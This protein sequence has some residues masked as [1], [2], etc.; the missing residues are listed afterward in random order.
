ML[1]QM[2]RRGTL[3]T[4]CFLILSVVGIV[5]ALQ[6]PVQMIPD[7]DVR[8]ISVRTQWPGASPQDVESEVLI[9][10][11]QFLR[12]VPNLSR[13]TAV[14][15]SGEATIEL[16]FPFNTDVT[17]A[18]LA[19]NNALNQV[20]AYPE[21]VR[22]PR[23]IASAF[24]SNSFMFFRVSPLAGN[25]QSV[26]MDLIVD[27]VDRQ[28]RS[29]MESVP[30]VSNVG[31]FGSADRQIK[32]WLDRNAL[33]D[34]GLTLTRVREVLR[35]RN[36]DFS[37]GDIDQGKRRYLLRTIG[38]FD[39]V[40]A[41]S[42]LILQRR[43]DAITRLGDVASIVLDHAEPTERTTVNGERVLIMPVRREAGAN[44]IQVKRAL[45]DLMPQINR[46]VLNPAGLELQ[47]TADD[48]GYVQASLQNVW[49][50]LALGAAL[51]TLV[52]F[53]FLRS[54]RTTLIGVIGI[55]LC[56]VAAVLGLAMTGRT[57]NVISL[58]GVAFALGMTLDNTIV[59]LDSIERRR[60]AG[61][62][63]MHAAIDGVRD[64]WP[65]LLAS[66]ATTVLV[67]LPVIFIREEAGQLYSD[68]A[69]AICA[70]IVASMAVAM[71]IVPSASAHIFQ[72]GGQAG[73]APADRVGFSL[74]ASLERSIAWLTQGLV[75]PIACVLLTVL[76][77]GFVFLV[78]TP[79]AS[80]LPE[81]EEPKTFASMSAPA[82]YNLST[83][84]AIADELEAYFLPFVA[85]NQTGREAS[86]PASSAVVPPI[87]YLIVRTTATRIRIIA[88]TVDPARLGELMQALNKKFRTYPD[89]RAFATRGSIIS[90]NDGGTRSI[91]VELSAADLP[92]LYASAE[93][94]FRRA[95]EVFVDPRVRATPSTRSLSQPM[96]EV[97]PDFERAAELGLTPQELGYAVSVVTDG[98]FA[99]EFYRGDEKID[100]YLHAATGQG[101]SLD[102][103]AGLQLQTPGGLVPLS[104]VAQVLDTVATGT[105]RRVNGARTL[106]VNI[107]P[108]D[109]VALE[110]GVQTVRDELVA[111]LQREGRIAPGVS[112]AIAGASDQLEATRQ[113]LLGNYA[114]A[115]VI[116]Y[117][118]LVAIL[119][120][121]GYP[122]LI[123]T[124]I[125]MGMA[126]G[127]L[128]LLALNLMGQWQSVLGLPAFSQPLDM[129]SM[130]GFLILMGTVVNN[131]ILVVTRLMH[132]LKQPG[133]AIGSAV[134]EAT[135]SRLR[136]IAMT[137]IT[138][139]CGLAPLVFWGGAGTELYRGVGAI[140][141][142]GLLGSA[143][144]SVTFLPALAVLVLRVRSR[145]SS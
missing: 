144:V 9:E 141:M 68:V 32:V 18:L 51:A 104:S 115:V 123:M 106:T 132:N 40:Q 73:G 22:R 126:G 54:A 38:R 2:V 39:D 89:M 129:I 56:T 31:L 99:D 83:M 63:R 88:E 47:L 36:R 139:L 80:Y 13:L 33:N 100:I 74:S 4:V 91:N 69:I 108:P 65:A 27:F 92:A 61:L 138:T 76:A 17:A 110:T 66:T 128:G 114:I 71:T 119:T 122:L 82:G 30:G 84:Q 125:P 55:P 35:T 21:T 105:I 111:V 133:I 118:L 87:R 14:A 19:V 16:E 81:G 72:S 112:V 107:I 11:E 44:V 60:R 95:G 137:T 94:V 28:V 67:F 34:R 130:L 5:A 15:E 62:D 103:I 86:P 109:D 50:N 102:D 64:V 121:W 42:G 25:P 124:T 90:S 1:E 10:Q 96:V 85:E 136:P 116:V 75:R 53:A 140:V 24:S 143:V 41:L 142:A 45:I 97:R 78:L 79:P 93:A 26:D 52:M 135:R 29:R 43:G 127:I 46:E 134:T 101:G 37:A 7:L 145:V 23:V 120:H 58:A 20:P 49:V 98:A 113:S 117:L 8:T 57:I 131:P 70:A 3:V 12:R 77:S 6:T 59:V 48:V